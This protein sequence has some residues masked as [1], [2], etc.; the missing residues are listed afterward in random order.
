MI[1]AK[2]NTCMHAYIATVKINGNYIRTVVHADS[3]T[4][5]RLLLQYCYGM[6]CVVT[7]P[8]KM[9]EQNM[10][11]DEFAIKAQKP[12]AAPTPAESRIQALQQQKER[13]TQAL[14]AERA[15]QKMA[16][17]QKALLKSNS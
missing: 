11:F 2:I 13:A 12:L 14:K 8:Q 6:N 5:A 4:H 17:A 16:K 3:A 7:A 9:D 10:R 15:R 1:Y